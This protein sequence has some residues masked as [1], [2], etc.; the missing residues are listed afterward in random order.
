MILSR[1]N[2]GNTLRRGGVADMR[3]TI[4]ELADAGFTIGE[5]TTRFRGEL[6]E[7]ERELIWRIACAETRR[8]RGE[9]MAPGRL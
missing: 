7:L 1:T 5:I 6:T 9:R 2:G 8:A 4:R 3:R